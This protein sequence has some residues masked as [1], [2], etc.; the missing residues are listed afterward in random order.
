[1]GVRLSI[2]K[3]LALV[4]LLLIFPFFAVT[5]WSYVNRYQVRVADAL[6]RR[7]DTARLVGATFEVW[8][9]EVRK[10][11]DL[12]GADLYSGSSNPAEASQD[13]EVMVKA[14]PSAWAVATDASGTVV[15]TTKPALRRRSLARNP[16]IA[17]LL[18]GRGKGSIGSGE[19][20]L[21]VRG[22]YIATVVADKNGTLRGVVATFI[23]VVRLHDALPLRLPGVGGSVTDANG[24]IVYQNEYPQLATSRADFRQY[25]FVAEALAGSPSR[26]THFVFPVT[27]QV[28]YAA[29][30]PIP[31]VPGW[32]AASSIDAET[33]VGEFFR[34]VRLSLLLETIAVVFAILVAV[35]V[36]R[37]I[38][39]SAAYLAG[40]SA[41]LGAGDFDHRVRLE[42]GDEMESI[43]DTLEES[44]SRLKNYVAGLAKIAEAGRRLSASLDP[45]Q[46]AATTV[47]GTEE[48]LDSIHTCI[49]L[50]RQDAEGF[51]SLLCSGAC[52]RLGVVGCL[53][54]PRVD[55]DWATETPTLTDARDIEDAE[56]AHV[57]TGCGA[58]T[59][60]QMPLVTGEGPL[61][62]VQVFSATERVGLEGRTELMRA[63]AAQVSASLQ[64]ALLY[65]ASRRLRAQ[66]EA[67]KDLSDSV[68]DVNARIMATLE[69]KETLHEVLGVTAKAVGAESGLICMAE[70]NEWTVAEVWHLPDDLRAR[71]LR[72]RAAIGY[73]IGEVSAGPGGAGRVRG[74]THSLVAQLGISAILDV[75]LLVGEDVVG[76]LALFLRS[77]GAAFT[78]EQIDFVNKVAASIGLALRNSLTF[79]IEHSI[80]ETLQES[81]LILPGAVEGMEFSSFYQAATG[82]GRVGGDFFDIFELEHDRI[83]IL[84]GDVSGK[85]LKAATLTAVA[86]NAIHAYAVEHF[87][88]AQILTRTNRLM[89]A[90]TETSAFVTVWFG[91]FD[92]STN[93]LAYSGGG[94]PP[95]LL[96]RA[97]GTVEELPSRGPLIGAYDQSSFG[98]GEALLEPGSVLVLYSD[99]VI[100]TRDEANN[101]LGLDLLRNAVSEIGADATT[102]AREIFN[103]VSAFGNGSLPDDVA[104]LAIGPKGA[105]GTRR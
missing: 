44:R 53:G 66:I 36:A 4:C 75:P 22:F 104:I 78:S 60:I 65:E 96:R 39:R 17:P 5:T 11:M 42:S 43:A 32:A 25:P 29:A 67:A 63:F 15:A 102:M 72:T 100:E 91:V 41:R 51:Q 31:S 61:G 54:E 52:E 99:G 58:R 23:D 35:L 46:V 3:K 90:A 9:S 85:G 82:P 48:L 33:V 45:S 38:Q 68:N 95:A 76:D 97:D 12:V 21:G 87:S 40:A 101:F 55:V 10:T 83:G 37:G 98:E 86:K 94:H 80:A 13:L 56:L 2:G 89:V 26:T 16:A 6:D 93:R 73:E 20:L 47:D 105:G 74:R 62:L 28:R 34:S 18:A 50:Y 69:V 14:Y 1:M 24:I 59:V 49:Y 103:F 79:E 92:R 57:V 77:P 88:P 84:L 70:G 19:D 71:T 81:L 64:N 8:V 30:V 7:V 27:R